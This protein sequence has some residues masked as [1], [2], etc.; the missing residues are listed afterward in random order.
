MALFGGKRDAKF[1]AAINAEL[2]NAVIDTEIEIYKLN[3]EQSDSNLYGESEN[4]SFYDSN[5]NTEELVIRRADN[6]AF[7]IPIINISGNII[8]VNASWAGQKV[9]VEYLYSLNRI[10]AVL[11]SPAGEYQIEKGIISTSPSHIEFENY[12]G[13][14]T[15]ALIEIVVDNQNYLLVYDKYKAL[16]KI[17]VDN[18]NRLFINGKLYKEPQSIYFEQP[19]MP[20]INSL[21]YDVENNRLMIWR[22]EQGV[23]GWF[24]A[25][26][27]NFGPVKEL[28]IFNPEN[29]PQD[30]KT[31][32]FEEERLFFSPGS[33]QVEV[34]IDNTVLMND[35]FLELEEGN[36]IQLV[37]ALDKPAFVEFRITHL[38]LSSNIGII[39]N[40]KTLAEE[41]L[42][43]TSSLE[44][45]IN[46]LEIPS[47]EEIDN[48][49]NE[50]IANLSIEEYVKENEL[51]DKMPNEIISNLFGSSFNYK[52]QNFLA[53]N[54]IEGLTMKDFILIFYIDSLNNSR[55]LIKDE[56]YS[57]EEESENIK[58]TILDPSLIGNL[59][60]TGIKTGLTT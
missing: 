2:L 35:Q 7:K 26:N 47:T 17:Y 33:N 45:S 11:V 4:K 44:N 58:I 27:E 10:D 13:Y 51:L 20:E 38:V 37:K 3:I 56:D 18:E 60:V 41:A 50:S 30:L 57:L 34:I 25:E 23:I 28:K 14:S 39:N 43:R 32:I 49:I 53:E 48:K 12:N 8:T 52:I 29:N 31:F 59:Y 40:I 54:I 46:N 19:E 16:R 24:Y 22:E 9:F 55:I 21:W 42:T 36:G 1:L 5:P 15:V 6:P